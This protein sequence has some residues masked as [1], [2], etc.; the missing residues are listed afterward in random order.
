MNDE[1][2]R[3]IT[4]LHPEELPGLPVDAGAL[5]QQVKRGEHGL[6]QFLALET[7]THNCY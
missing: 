1:M 7:H 2:K 5:S 4:Y 3:P 6:L